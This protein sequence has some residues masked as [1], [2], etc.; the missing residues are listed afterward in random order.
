MSFPLWALE[1]APVHVLQA[2]QEGAHVWA[3]GDR[4]RFEQAIRDELARRTDMAEGY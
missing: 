3:P 1:R 4:W 2:L